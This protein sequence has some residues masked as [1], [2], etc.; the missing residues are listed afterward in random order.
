[1]CIHGFENTSGR[2]SCAEMM[3][4]LHHSPVLDGKDRLEIKRS[5]DNKDKSVMYLLN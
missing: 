5:K 1:M 2:V 4:V 3:E